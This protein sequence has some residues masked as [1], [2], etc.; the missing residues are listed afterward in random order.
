MQG[1]YEKTVLEPE[2]PFRLFFNDGY[3]STPHHWHEDIEIIYL[4]EGVLKVG[5]NKDIYNLAVGDILIIGPGEVHCFFKEKGSS[6]R[7]V[8]QF[9]M[10]IYDTFLSGTKDVR[11]I[12]P[13]FY[14]SK[15]LTPG[16]EIHALMEKQIKEIIYECSE[17]KEGYKLILKARLYDLAGILIRHLPEEE[18]SPENE[19]R[20]KERLQKLD[21]VLQYVEKNY[22]N[23]ID[24][25]EIS[26]AVGFSKYYF[27]RFFKENTGMTFLG[28]LNNFRITKSEWYL[29]N[30]EESITEVAFKSGFNSVKTFNRVFKNLKGC[31][32]MEYKKIVRG[33]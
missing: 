20:Q 27:T 8:I 23:N 13:M 14:R 33:L 1:S 16:S 18:Y 31:T 25:D 29:M 9:R 7:A 10:S 12:K 21:K 22:Q 11:T 24:L 26:K 3:T 6:N 28:Y 2:F 5:V 17:A 15:F 30:D 32:P 4:V 19:T